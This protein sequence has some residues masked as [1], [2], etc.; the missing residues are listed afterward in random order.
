MSYSVNYNPE[1]K[2]R[3]PSAEN[4]GRKFSVKLLLWCAAI[5]VLLLVVS[6]GEVLRICLP[7][8]PDVTADAFSAM[9]EQIGAGESVQ[10]AFVDFCKE[11]IYS[12]S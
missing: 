5:A 3:Y 9:V 1:L 7:G 12:G 8:E 6:R 11:I 10:E 2:D 4:P